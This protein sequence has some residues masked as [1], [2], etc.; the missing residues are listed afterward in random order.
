MDKFGLS[1]D[2]VTKQFEQWKQEWLTAQDQ[3]GLQ[4][5]FNEAKQLFK[6]VYEPIVETIAGINS[7]MKKLGET[8]VQKIIEQI[9]FLESRA[10]EANQVQNEAAIRQLERI[11][12][13]LFPLGKPQERVY[14]ILGYLNK[15]GESFLQQLMELPYTATGNHRIIYM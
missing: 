7:G 9:E 10:V 1:L 4:A 6:Q 12:L 14:N 15:Y 3:L 5:K 13:S 8:N 2:I 11:K